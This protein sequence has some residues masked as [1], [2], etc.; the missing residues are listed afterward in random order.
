MTNV[1][2]TKWLERPLEHDNLIFELENN[3]PVFFKFLQDFALND[4][5][6]QWRWSTL[7]TA[8]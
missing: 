6:F 5:Q 4:L 8:S 7:K 1:H 3:L 2:L